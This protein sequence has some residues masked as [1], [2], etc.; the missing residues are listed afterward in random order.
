MQQAL[1][2]P[3]NH[4]LKATSRAFYLSLVVLPNG[5]RRPLSLAYLL[6]RAADTIADSTHTPNDEKA[7]I[8]IVFQSALQS[9][10]RALYE[11][12]EGFRGENNEETRLISNLSTVFQELHNCDS[13]EKD[14]IIR[15]VRTLIDGMLW[16]QKTF[17]SSRNQT[18]L[19]STEE[20]EQYTYMVAGCVGPFWSKSC[21][22]NERDLTHLMSEENL[23]TAVEY[24]KGLQWVNIL[25]DVVKDQE[26]ARYYLPP[27]DSK[28]FPTA[29]IAKSRR[30]LNA[31]KS[32]LNYP[33]LY[34]VSHFRNRYS[35]FLPL[36]LA[37]RTL[38]KLYRVGGPVKGRRTKVARWEVFFWLFLGLFFVCNKKLLTLVFNYLYNRTESSLL[39]LESPRE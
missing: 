10:P 20:L 25:R 19:L 16:D 36:V 8:L 29:F 30:A 24:G 15:V 31:I 33:N 4:L 1:S 34:P 28:D 13:A 11:K 32:A 23:A 17:G 6:A 38:E 22:T 35:V 39:K 14:R 27:L 5:P 18:K 26:Q 2:S 12:T 21:S 3:M 37:L 7:D 9:D